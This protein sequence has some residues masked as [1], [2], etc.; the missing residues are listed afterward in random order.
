MIFTGRTKSGVRIDP[1]NAL[2]I[3]AVWACVRF[4]SQSIG[5]LPWK[6]IDDRT[7]LPVSMAV[8]AQRVLDRPSPEY[9]SMQFREVMMVWALRYGNGYAEIEPDEIGRPAALHPIHPTRVLVKRDPETLKLYY[10]IDQGS[11]LVPVIL[12]PSQMF[13]LRGMG[14]GPVG[15]SVIA[16]AA[17]SLG[18]T[19]AVQMF[20]AGFFGEGA[21]PAGVVTTK[22]PL[23]PDGLAALQREFKKIYSGAKNAGKTAFLDNDMEYKPLTVDPD[24]G[25]FI[26]TNQFLIDEVCRWFG[27]P[28][29]KIYKLLNA[30][31]SNIEHQSIEVVMDS[32]KPWAQRFEDEA[33]YKLLGN[34]RAGYTNKINLKGLLAGDTLARLQWYR[35][36]RNI[37]VFTVNDILELEDMPLIGGAAGGDKR[38]MQSQY[39]TLEKIGE[40]IAVDDGSTG[41]TPEPE[42]DPAQAPSQ[43]PAPAEG[44]DDGQEPVE[45]RFSENEYHAAL[46]GMREC[47]V[48]IGAP[49]I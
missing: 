17:E 31:F 45:D 21:T 37:G 32:L 6:V 34:N 12:D 26:E 7:K 38:V 9:S 4:L 47:A 30:T 46:F 48:K 13:H 29:H 35:E 23:T 3:S 15:L 36:L 42:P 40:D 33:K 14:E 20:G 5:A 16:Y 22:K 18:W 27:V 10:V 25:Q 24:K 28:P 39:T 2:T 41:G 1:E 44:E 11:G 19:K 8:P 43:E 49:V